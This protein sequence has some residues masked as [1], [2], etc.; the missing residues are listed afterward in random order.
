[1]QL[2]SQKLD[3]DFDYFKK[4]YDFTFKFLLEEGQRTLG[5]CNL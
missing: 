2:L 5:E 1:M 4:V 3:N